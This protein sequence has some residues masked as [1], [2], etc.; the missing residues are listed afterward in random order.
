MTAVCLCK[1]YKKQKS[2]RPTE[3]INS[4]LYASVEMENIL[5]ASNTGGTDGIYTEINN[6]PST[7]KSPPVPSQN[8]TYSLIPAVPASSKLPLPGEFAKDKDLFYV[9]V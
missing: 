6:V 9:T 4:S 2:K 1:R 7:F 3:H 5:S 8:D